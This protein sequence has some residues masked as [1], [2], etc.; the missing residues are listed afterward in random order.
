MSEN[1]I[2]IDKDET[3]VLGVIFDGVFFGPETP[4]EIIQEKMCQLRLKCERLDI[5][6]RYQIVGD[7]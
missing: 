6:R 3:K 1:R 5:N 4:S 2:V 7:A